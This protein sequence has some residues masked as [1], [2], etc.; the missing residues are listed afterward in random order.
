MESF[1]GPRGWSQLTGF[2]GRR[3]SGG[4]PIPSMG[5]LYIS[6]HLVDFYGKCTLRSSN[7]AME[8]EPFEDVL[9]IKHGDIPASYV[10]LPEGS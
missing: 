8:N 3:K 10:S 2:L 4:I 7:V 1:V 6:L 9:P 5:R